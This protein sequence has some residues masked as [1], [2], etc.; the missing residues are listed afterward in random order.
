MNFDKQIAVYD[1]SVTARKYIGYIAESAG[2][3]AFIGRD[4]KLYFR[5]IYQDKVELSIDLF[6]EY[7]WGEEFKISKVSYEDGTRS[8]K[9]GDDTNNNLW[10]DQDNVFIVDEEQTEK[11]YNNVKGLTIN[12]FEGSSII[13]PAIDIGDKI[14]ID[15]KPIVYQGEMILQGKFV[16]QF[17]S[18]IQIKQK[19]ETTVKKESQ[20]SINRKVKSEI[21]QIDGKITRLIQEQSETEN[22]LT[23]VEQTVDGIAQRV[24]HMADV[25]N[26]VSGVRTI[27]LENCV[28]GP[29]LELHIFGNNNVFKHLYP[30][31]DLLVSDDLIIYGDSRITVTNNGETKLYELGVTDV[32]RQNEE[33]QD[34]YILVDG[35]AKIIRRV[36]KDGTTLAKEAVEELGE[37]SIPLG[38][39]TNTIE[40]LNYTASMEAK[41]AI[42]NDYTE[43]FATK[44]EM[45]SSITQTA[46]EI[47][48]EVRKKVDENE[49]I[50]SI[51]QSPEAVG[52]KANKIELTANDVL[53]LLAGNEIN[54]TSKNII[55][56]SNSFN[57]DKNGNV[58]IIDNTGTSGSFKIYSKGTEYE[59]DIR[60][61]GQFFQGPN[62]Y[63]G[64]EADF[65]LQGG[66]IKVSPTQEDWENCTL[67]Q[68]GSVECLKL[69]QT[70]LARQKKNFEKL[71]DNAIDI[72]KNIDIYKYNLKGENDT[73]KKHIG[74]VI[75]DGYNYSK[76]VTSLDNK[77][78]DNYSF[79]SLCCKAIQEQQGILE[80][81]NEVI[82]QLQKE[83]KELKEG[84]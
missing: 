41:F 53:N 25:T 20:K 48:L 38:D 19:E 73:D 9:F 58:S 74:F 54:L 64:I 23:Q 76:E 65:T 42:Q 15:G 6:G 37:Y 3:F 12:S 14:I 63:V 11:I 29:L 69:T 70:S 47:N 2:G 35:Q 18:K 10:I 81:Q 16:A 28:A 52:I 5:N 50:S 57:V 84:K 43:I 40:I 26:T 79:T 46:E 30:S 68:N 33:V 61:F 27:T 32:L 45:N 17:V 51:N 31:D 21:D 62:G 83:I 72:I 7:K 36:S 59:V 78:V 75:G 67:I 24:E 8:F 39:G 80:Q 60:S 44:V 13:D 49:I 22:K 1:N 56:K 55:L 4:G 77:G 71:Q 66:S 82:E 34:E